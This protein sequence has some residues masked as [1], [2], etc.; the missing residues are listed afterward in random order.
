MSMMTKTFLLGVGVGG[1]D[2]NT[3]CCSFPW[4]SPCTRGRVAKRKEKPAGRSLLYYGCRLWRINQGS[5][6]QGSQGPTNQIRAEHG[7]QAG[8]PGILT[9][10]LSCSPPLPHPMAGPPPRQSLLHSRWFWSHSSFIFPTLPLKFSGIL[11]FTWSK[12]NQNSHPKNVSETLFVLLP[13]WP[14][15]WF[16]KDLPGLPC[17]RQGFRSLIREDPTWYEAAKPVPHNSWACAL[18]FASH[19]FRAH[20][21]QLLKSVCLQGFKRSHSNEKSEHR[22]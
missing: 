9:S 13:P 2:Y 18:A 4:N 16:L 5:E 14:L 17:R 8:L 3:E 22:N 12:R 11:Y 19:K 20:V 6:D 15:K 21:L 7:H 1:A 10:P